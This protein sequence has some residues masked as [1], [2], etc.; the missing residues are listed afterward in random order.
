MTRGQVAALAAAICTA[1]TCSLARADDL[2]DL[3]AQHRVEIVGAGI[4]AVHIR[5]RLVA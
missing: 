1:L 5:A 3:V 2:V 4:H